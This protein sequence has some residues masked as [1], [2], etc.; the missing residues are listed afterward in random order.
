[1]NGVDII[2]T[3][4]NKG[5]ES[6]ERVDEVRGGRSGCSGLGIRPLVMARTFSACLQG[7]TEPAQLYS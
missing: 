3:A 1:M 4:T 7:L 6:N 2:G 5:G